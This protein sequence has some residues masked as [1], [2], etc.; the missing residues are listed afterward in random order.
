MTVTLR[1]T[2]FRKPVSSDARRRDVRLQQQTPERSPPFN[3]TTDSFPSQGK[4]LSPFPKRRNRF[5]LGHRDETHRHV[6][7]FW[8]QVVQTWVSRY[9]PDLDGKGMTGGIRAE[10]SKEKE[11]GRRLQNE[12]MN[13]KRQCSLQKRPGYELR[14][15]EAAQQTWSSFNGSSPKHKS[16]HLRLEAFQTDR[17]LALLTESLNCCERRLKVILTASFSWFSCA[18]VRNNVNGCDGIIHHEWSSRA[19][20]ELLL[21]YATAFARSC[22][23]QPPSPRLA[24]TVRCNT[25]STRC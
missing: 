19:A 20:A 8:A 14:S 2:G 17:D 16:C 23:V 3:I 13:K 9:V 15:Y 5:Y 24:L 4:P 11:G 1:H 21:L 12:E 25:E 7:I 6:E 18:D 22:R 10:V